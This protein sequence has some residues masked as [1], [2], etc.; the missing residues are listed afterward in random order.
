M[1]TRNVNLTDEQSR[2]VDEM[3]RSG[4]YQNASEAMRD[5][6]RTLQDRMRADEMKLQILRA[7]LQAGMDD[8]ERG[9]VEYY[10]LDD[11]AGLMQEMIAEA[12][13][14]E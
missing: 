10:D 7:H 2:F 5:A 8:I 4:R 3:V 12:L 6:V 9:D 1:P 11:L 13:A 14:E